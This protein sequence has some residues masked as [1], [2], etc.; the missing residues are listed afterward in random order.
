MELFLV[1]GAVRD[2]IMGIKSKDWDF[3]VVLSEFNVRDARFWGLTDFE[4][5]R[6]RL[7]RRGFEVFVDT[8][9]F[10]TL[11]ARGPKGFTFAGVDFGNQTFDFVM[12]RKESGYTDGRR[13][14]A[15][16]AGDLMDD[17]SRRDFT[18][19]AI[20][21]DRHGNLIDPFNGQQDIA[22]KIIRAVG[23]ARE[24]IIDEDA[25]RGLRALRF[26][27]QKGFAIDEEVKD[28]LRSKAFQ[29]ALL[30]VSTERVKDELE[31]MFKVDTIRT[32]DLI[33][34]FSLEL[35]LFDN[36]G[37]RLMPTMKG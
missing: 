31:K 27:V 4:F 37:L 5:M 9:E 6:D 15:V 32:L 12:A 2:E 24:R 28:V 22:D 35:V 7:V 23:N 26:A 25:L 3:S 17:L 1:G 16:E 11:R 33:Q 19:N 21:K 20:A 18:V 10:F 34:E 36:T 30:S 8:P 29:L 14:D 13:P